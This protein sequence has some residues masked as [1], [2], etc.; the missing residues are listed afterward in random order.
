MENIKAIPTNY[1]RIN[2]RSRLEARWALFFDLLGIPYE[3]E[4][5]K[6]HTGVSRYI[7]DFRLPS[8]DI[9]GLPTLLEVKGK[10]P[11]PLEIERTAAVGAFV[12]SG[13]LPDHKIVYTERGPSGATELAVV[14][15][16]CPLCGVLGFKFTGQPTIGPDNHIHCPV[17]ESIGEWYDIPQC[18]ASLWP[19][20]DWDLDRSPTISLALEYANTAKF[21]DPNFYE[22]A[23]AFKGTIARLKEMRVYASSETLTYI[24]AVALG[25]KKAN[26][27]HYA[28]PRDPAHKRLGCKP[29]EI[30]YGKDPDRDA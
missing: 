20:S 2:F 30:T 26:D 10:A 3:Y 16:Q 7:P 24:H 19:N 4:P 18:F 11:S 1:N 13:S 28:G 29:F 25:V 27:V 14:I 8:F 21:E 12:V 6:Y 9:L 17:L 23:T 5:E 15:D 22:L